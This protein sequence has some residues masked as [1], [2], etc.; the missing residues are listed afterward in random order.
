MPVSEPGKFI[1]SPF[2]SIKTIVNPD[3]VFVPPLSF[4][5][6]LITVREAGS[7]LQE[8]KVSPWARWAPTADDPTWIDWGLAG[9]PGGIWQIEIFDSGAAVADWDKA[10][11]KEIEITKI[12]NKVKVFLISTALSP[13][14]FFHLG[15]IKNIHCHKIL[16]QYVFDLDNLELLK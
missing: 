5:T 10:V 8:P 14:K 1:T 16:L 2:E 12:V 11:I 13:K 6:S 7:A 15:S 4:V 9:F 3:A